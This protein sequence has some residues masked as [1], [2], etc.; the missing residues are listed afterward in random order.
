[1]DAAGERSCKKVWKL[2]LLVS[3][4]SCLSSRVAVFSRRL[5]SGVRKRCQFLS[6]FVKEF[7]FD[8]DRAIIGLE[9]FSVLW[10][11]G[12]TSP[13]NYVLQVL[14]CRFNVGVGFK[15]DI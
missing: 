6:P 3:A 12:P 1:V 5:L 2:A 14:D 15:G 8:Q 11:C 13:L 9:D 10:G 7:L 4:R